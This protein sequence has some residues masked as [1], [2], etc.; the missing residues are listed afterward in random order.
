MAR[1]QGFSKELYAWFFELQEKHPEAH[2]S[3][4]GRGKDDQTALLHKKATRAAWTK[5]AH[6]WNAALDIFENGGDLKNIYETAFFV[7]VL[8]PNLKPFLK[9]YGQ[10]DSD[11]FELPHVELAGW[12]QMAKAGTLKLVEPE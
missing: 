11:F 2:V 12:R 6:N 7:D 8:K 1:Y 9:W 10:P 4:A 3:C 5:S